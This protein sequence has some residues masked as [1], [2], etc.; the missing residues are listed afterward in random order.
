L[1]R[2]STFA[3]GFVRWGFFSG[4]HN[5]PFPFQVRA[6]T[7]RRWRRRRLI[8]E[9]FLMNFACLPLGFGWRLLR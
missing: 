6:S 1:T 7:T 3:C 5:V 8:C 9:Y 4:L 2:M